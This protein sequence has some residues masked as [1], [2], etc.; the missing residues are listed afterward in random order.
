MTRCTNGAWQQNGNKRWSSAP[1]AVIAVGVMAWLAAVPALPAAAQSAT[2]APAVDSSAR[3]VPRT[4][5]P[6]ALVALLADASQR[7]VLPR[8]LISYKANVETEIVVLLRREEGTEAVAAIE[9]V[10]SSLR[11]ARTGLYEQHVVGYRAQQSGPNVSMLT[12][13]QTGW[14][15]PTLY[16]NRLRVQ[17]RTNGSSSGS[18]DANRARGARSVRR[19]G[20]DTLP[21]VHPLSTDRD[22]Y[23]SYSGGDTVVTIRLAERSIPIARVRVQP[24]ADITAP[25][26]L[27]DGEMELDASR[28]T[29][30]RLRGT[31]VR[32]GTKPRTLAGALTR[33]LGDAVAFIEYENGER[34]GNFWLPAKQRVELQAT[35]PILGDGR[36]VIRM[37]SQF[38]DMQVNDT[39]P[40]ADAL[41]LADSTRPLARRMLTFAKGDSLSRFDRWRSDVGALT[42]GMHADDFLDV[43][44]D[45]WRPTGAPRVDWVVPRA[46]DLFH[47]NRV[48]GAFTGFGAKW[49]LRDMA[50]GVVVR[51]NAGWAWSEGTARG[52]LSVLRTRGPWTIEARAGRSLD[53]TNDFAMPFDS[54]STLGALFASQDPYD[55]V[56][57]T[58]GTLAVTREVGKRAL[59]WR[60][61]VGVADDRYR[62]ATYVRSPFGG[63]AYR[64][65]RGVDEGRYVRSAASIEWH[66]DVSAEFVKPGMSA[67][68]KYERGDGTL[69]FQRI[70]ARLVAREPLGPFIAIMRAD[71]GTL[72]G[73]RPPPQQ[74]FELGEQQNLPGYKDKEFAGTRAATVL[75]TVQYNAPWLRQPIRV[76]RLFLPALAPGASV[77]VQSG[78]AEAPNDA[79]RQSIDRLLVVDPRV[80]ASYAPVSRPTNGIR[81]S[82]TAGLR[83]FSGGVFVGATRPVDQA[84]PWRTLITF[85]QQW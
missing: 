75:G 81:A 43:A 58:S 42:D 4:L 83:F 36:A 5:T 3:A 26:V 65:N 73:R 45:R 40:S 23:Y 63:K 67:R 47:F 27:F 41:A 84:A 17:R 61:E 25:V 22:R 50:P 74:L 82:V 15:I 64:A 33:S 35:L 71:V 34:L 21:A 39:T 60:A 13:F 31:F 10:A 57:R 80:L 24:R 9:Q 68:L 78:W 8:D 49:S 79:A 72:L 12:A 6:R 77:G 30:V 56:D 28:G 14:L 76:G 69:D 19:D 7:N 37:V 20:A 18:S 55:Y 59:L 1:H 16:G 85:G 70:E 38:R 44:P 48:E 2:T 11:W 51:A 53:N 62:A 32:A 54:G 46:A 29:L 66:P 52:R